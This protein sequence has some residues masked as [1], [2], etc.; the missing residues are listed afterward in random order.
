MQEAY[1][2]TTT[3][4][5]TSNREFPA[6]RPPRIL[7]VLM[8]SEKERRNCYLKLCIMRTKM[9]RSEMNMRFFFRASAIK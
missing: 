7:H 5:V 2:T 8:A 4:I 6:P 3:F 1:T 9:S